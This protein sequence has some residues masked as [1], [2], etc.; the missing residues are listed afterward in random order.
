MKSQKLLFIIALFCS[1]TIF[2]QDISV[3]KRDKL[4]SEI[5][6]QDREFSVYFPPSY[7]TTVNQKYPVLY[8]LDGDY[9]F[10][11]VAGFLELQGAI[12]EIIP[13][14]ILVAISG[15][16]TNEYRKN[17]KPKIEGVE[18]SGNAEEVVRFIEKELI[19][20][21]NK[22]YKTAD[23][24]ILGGHSVGGIFVINTAINHP[25][26][27]NNYIAISP[28]LWWGNNAMEEVME[29]T[30]G[31]TKSTTASLYISLANEE[32]MGV[33]K[34]LK[35]VPKSIMDK[36]IKY[37]E[38]PT[39]IHNS[40][41]LSSYKWALG[42][43]FKNW[44]VKEEY[45]GSAEALKKHYAEVQKQYGSIFNIPFTVLGNTHYMLQKNDKERAKVQMALKELN[46]NAFV[47]FNTYR[48]G[49]LVTSKD[50]EEAE[51]LLKDALAVNP[52]NFDSYNV[53]A[54]IESAK[55]NEMEANET[56]NKAINLA[57]QQRARQWQINELLE[58]KA[59]I[60]KKP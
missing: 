53:L 28:A 12:S 40:V 52:N 10:Q 23:Y 16:G 1:L 8:I 18:D 9:N 21:V 49:K 60:N 29:K 31:K 36:N 11:Y 54:K 5:L 39:E 4:H 57:N 26:L 37:Q 41:G 6:Q 27:F 7:N 56:I 14:M 17:C 42:A 44:Y 22:N 50:Y 38:F 58:T 43:I 35:K 13:E 59:E 24:K 2:A 20:Y 55:G 15:K 19:P 51:Q 32:G 25:D 34:F 33:D 47:L 46:P 45:F 48:A 30:W 3:G